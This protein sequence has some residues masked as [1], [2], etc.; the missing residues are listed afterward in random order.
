[1]T[2][3]KA[4]LW[5]ACGA[6]CLRHV[7]GHGEPGELYSS[8]ALT[9]WIFVLDQMLGEFL[10]TQTNL[11][12]GSARY[13]ESYQWAAEDARASNHDMD[14]TLTGNPL[15][16]YSLF[17]R[18]ALY[19]SEVVSLQAHAHAHTYTNHILLHEDGSPVLPSQRDFEGAANGLGRL[20]RVYDLPITH[21]LQGRI[22]N[23]TC[24]VKLGV[25]DC[26]LVANVSRQ[27]GALVTAWEWYR[28][29]LL[30]APENDTIALIKQEMS[31]LL[32]ELYDEE[33]EEEEEKEEKEEKEEEKKKK[34]KPV[35]SFLESLPFDIEADEQER[36]FNRLCR[37]ETFL[38]EQQQRGLQCHVSSMGSPYLL[39]RPAKYEQ[40]LRHP[41][42]YLYYDVISQNEIEVVQQLSE[43]AVS[44]VFSVLVKMLVSLSTYLCFLYTV[45]DSEMTN[46]NFRETFSKARSPTVWA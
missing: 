14:L 23:T 29:A 22:L 33:E 35:Q 11:T 32:Q 13:L 39:L 42:L 12:A 18:L 19:G 37:G 34:E 25:S 36:D 4:V 28:Q 24:S 27:N 26:V 44:V 40:L 15:Q 7:S 31:S 8:I 1:M 46:R 43:K 10:A 38:T 41:E 16:V 5:L 20:Q 30:L 3:F 45:D 21:L 2:V 9:R 6:S 17:K